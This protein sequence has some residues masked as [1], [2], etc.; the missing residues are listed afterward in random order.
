MLFGLN[1]KDVSMVIMFSPFN[2]LNSIL[3]AGGRA[4]R[5]QGNTKRKKC[6]IYTLYNNTDIRTNAPM[7]QSVQQF[8]R[9]KSC[10][11]DKMN[12]HFSSHTRTT[13]DIT[14]CCS[15]CSLAYILKFFKIL[16]NFFN[17]SENVQR[18]ERVRIERMG[19]I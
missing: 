17:V 3:Q 2:S 1:I 14:W 8:C 11:K 12:N 10:L 4:G 16:I 18:L 13:Q 19:E 7:E 15:S 5:R 9:E 6:V